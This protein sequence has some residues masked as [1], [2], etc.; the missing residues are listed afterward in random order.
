M[1][2]KKRNQWPGR[3]LESLLAVTRPHRYPAVTVTGESNSL[4]S[5]LLSLVG[6]QCLS[7]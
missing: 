6:T 3:K 4:E 5:G 1:E 2:M 7:G